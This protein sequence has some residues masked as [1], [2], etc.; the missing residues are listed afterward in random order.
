MRLPFR[1]R[2]R[3]LPFSDETFL[4]GLTLGALIGAA[5][6]GSTLWSRLRRSGRNAADDPGVMHPPGSIEG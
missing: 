2:R 1:D 4:R 6:A 3:A 5:I